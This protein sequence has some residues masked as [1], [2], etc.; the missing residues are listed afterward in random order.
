VEGVD[1]GVVETALLDD[2]FIVDAGAEKL[3]G[4]KR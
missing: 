1:D 2:S 3:L 4:K